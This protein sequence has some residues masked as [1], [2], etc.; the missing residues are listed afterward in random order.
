M[1][2]WPT[3]AMS[4][5]TSTRV[6]HGGS[7]SDARASEQRRRRR[8]YD[9]ARASP[10]C[11]LRSAAR[12]GSKRRARRRAARGPDRPPPRR[13][14]AGRD[15]ATTPVRSR[16]ARLRAARGR[17]R[18]GSAAGGVG[19]SPSRGPGGWLESGR[20][21]S[22]RSPS[23]VLRRRRDAARASRATSASA[24]S[25]HSRLKRASR[26]SGASAS[27]SRNASRAAS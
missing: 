13:A 7:A 2:C 14:T 21:G 11:R 26:S 15:R 4:G 10:A 27:A 3:N 25:D 8:S 24:R 19:P 22:G 17:R 18:C 12:A 5:S 9:A 6:R 16:L 1:I 23:L 20:F